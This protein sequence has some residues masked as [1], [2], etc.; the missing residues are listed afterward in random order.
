MGDVADAVCFGGEAIQLDLLVTLKLSPQ[1]VTPM[2]T[3]L[4]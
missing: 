4:D 3:D 2:A 1:L